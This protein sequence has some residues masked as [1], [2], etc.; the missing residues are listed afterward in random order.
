MSTRKH[1]VLTDMREASDTVLLLHNIRL[2][3]V[4]AISARIGISAMIVPSPVATPF[5]PLNF[6][7]IEKVWPNITAPA[8]KTAMFAESVN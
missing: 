6:R 2:N 8:T 7:K 4:N 5:P 3:S 1:R